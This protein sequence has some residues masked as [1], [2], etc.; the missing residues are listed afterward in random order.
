MNIPASSHWYII[1]AL[2]NTVLSTVE[3]GLCWHSDGSVVGT[4]YG[5]HTIQTTDITMA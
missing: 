4:G 1:Y 3:D 2:S 5:F